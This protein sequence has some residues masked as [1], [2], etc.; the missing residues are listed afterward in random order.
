M[1]ENGL[2]SLSQA[3][4]LAHKNQDEGRGNGEQGTVKSP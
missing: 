2:N 4:G 3:V 1:A